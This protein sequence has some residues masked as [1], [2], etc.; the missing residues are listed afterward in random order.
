M[1][2]TDAL[3]WD[4]IIRDLRFQSL[5]R[6][7]SLFLRGLMA[8]L[9]AYYF[10]LPIGVAKANADIAKWGD[11]Q[12]SFMG[13]EQ[14]LIQ[15]K[16]PGIISIPLGFLAVLIGSLLFRDRR[17]ESMWNEVYVRQ[18]TGLLMSK[19]VRL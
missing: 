6:R 13:L 15:L 9:V 14:P 16:N 18:N 11:A 5:H 7:K 17:A 3:D 4:A 2:A 10:M 19:S 1:A 12:T 8:L